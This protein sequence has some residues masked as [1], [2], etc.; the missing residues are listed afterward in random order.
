M[1]YILLIINYT[2]NTKH[3]REFNTI[4]EVNNAIIKMVGE[5]RKHDIDIRVV[6]SYTEFTTYERG[7]PWM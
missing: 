2:E 7:W 1:G 6:T 3:G 5:H 4:S